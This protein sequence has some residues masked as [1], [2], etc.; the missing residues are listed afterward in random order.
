MHSV[1]GIRGGGGG[2]DEK[3]HDTFKIKIGAISKNRIFLNSGSKFNTS[4]KIEVLEEKT[5]CPLA[6]VSEYGRFSV[7]GARD[8]RGEI[9]MSTYIS[10][11]SIPEIWTCMPRLDIERDV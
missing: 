11:S 3:I 10:V 6:L 9:C 5:E 8:E 7:L 2:G 4:R 1:C